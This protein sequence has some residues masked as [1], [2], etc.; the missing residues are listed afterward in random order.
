M[1]RPAGDA[2]PAA[3]VAVE[4]LAAHEH[5]ALAARH[6]HHV[7]DVVVNL[8]HPVGVAVDVAEAVR[9]GRAAVVGEGLAGR[10][11]GAD[12]PVE[13]G[14]PLVEIAGPPQGEPGRLEVEGGGG[15]RQRPDRRPPGAVLGLRHLSEDH[16]QRQRSGALAGAGVPRGHRPRG[17]AHRAAGQRAGVPV[18]RHPARRRP[19]RACGETERGPLPEPEQ[20]RW[21]WARYASPS[22]WPCTT[23]WRRASRRRRAA[24]PPPEAAASSPRPP[25]TSRPSPG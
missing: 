5:H 9:A 18:R 7:D 21:P 10:A 25:S 2:G 3:P 11:V 1:P 24:S 17:R 14:A 12:P 19:R 6:E 22:A 4:H 23:G 16:P 20:P 15:P 13:G 8:G